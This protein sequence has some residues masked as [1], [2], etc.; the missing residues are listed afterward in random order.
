M[1]TKCKGGYRLS[2]F[3]EEE[4][5]PCSVTPFFDCK[6]SQNKSI[7]IC[8]WLG[9]PDWQAKEI[10]MARQNQDTCIAC[11]DKIVWINPIKNL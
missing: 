9:D 2:F 11:G 4:D 8:S 6:V 3:I 1:I 5:K 7:D 10:A